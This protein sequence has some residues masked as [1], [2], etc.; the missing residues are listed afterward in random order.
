MIEAV[1][2]S[3]P[4][5]WCARRIVVTVRGPDGTPVV[6]HVD[7]PFARVGSHPDCEVVLRG[8]D[9]PGQCLYLHATEQGIYCL[10]LKS[11]NLA[12]APP[13]GWLRPKVHARLG[14]YRINASFDDEG[15][16]PRHVDLDPRARE[17]AA[18]GT[19]RLRIE[20]QGDQRPLV[21]KSWRRQLT[22]VGRLSPS[23]LRL[24]HPKVSKTHC[25]LFYD[26]DMLWAVD[27]L[28]SRGTRVDG[29][30]IEAAQV[31]PGQVLEVGG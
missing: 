3:R 18:G 8:D 25:V 2:L 16:P 20:S 29:R 9:V 23:T 22:L 10:G 7:K 5:L 21:E 14:P 4:A 26:Q 17:S 12:A 6:T 30:R 27:L 1:L 11:G 13:N 24:V 31:L 28:S 15:P 19:L